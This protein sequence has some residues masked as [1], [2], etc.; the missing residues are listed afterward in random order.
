LPI[1]QRGSIHV[2]ESPAVDGLKWRTVPR[3]EPIISDAANGWK[4][5]IN[6]NS[7]DF[8]VIMKGGT[9]QNPR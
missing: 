9:Y 1:S 3:S 5:T 4:M 8:L 2:I 7:D 6:S